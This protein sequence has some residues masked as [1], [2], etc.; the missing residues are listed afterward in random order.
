MS[1]SLGMAAAVAAGAS[2]VAIVNIKLPDDVDGVNTM[3]IR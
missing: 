2:D 1:V 3:R